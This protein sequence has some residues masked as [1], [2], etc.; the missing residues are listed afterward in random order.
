MS[1]RFVFSLLLIG[2]CFVASTQKSPA[3]VKTS[4]ATQGDALQKRLSNVDELLRE[5][6]KNEWIAGATALVI[7]DGKVV[8]HKSVGVKDLQTKEPLQNDAIYRIA[9]QTKAVTSVGI[10]MLMEEGKL[11]LDDLVSTY[12]PE[13]KNTP[14]L[15][16]FNA[17]D[18]TYTTVPAKRGITIRDLLTHTSGIGYAQIGNAQMN[19]IYAKAGIVGGI[20]VE[21]LVLGDKMKLLGSLPLFHQPG[22]RFTYGLNTD[23][24]GYLIEVI[25]RTTLDQFFQKRIFEPLVMKDTY[26]YLPSSKQSRLVALHTEDKAQNNKLIKATGVQNLN[27]NFYP[28]YPNLK[29]TYFSGGGGLS[30][31]A[32]D[33]G[34]FM[35]MLLN[36]GSYKGKRVLSPASVRMMTT[37][38]IDS[39]SL[40]AGKKF[41]LGFEIVQESSKTTPLS[42]GSYSWGGMFSSSYWIDPKEKMVAQLFLNQYPMSHGE[43]H[44]KFKSLVYAALK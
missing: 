27:G 31:T 3:V 34:L 22:E 19:A 6:V 10:L 12:I 40:G 33:F 1:K 42:V 4:S 41:G 2:L 7:K 37:N 32:H 25:S 21:N 16:H 5:Y 23:L 14:V 20:G 18:T 28:N 36:G 26:F 35:Q 38:Q 24:L 17:P 15:Q 11:Q 8:Y 44:N 13:F 9:S 39:L 29:G 30:S 43:I